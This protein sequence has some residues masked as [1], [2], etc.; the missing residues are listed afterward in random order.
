MPSLAHTTTSVDAVTVMM[1]ETRTWKDV[2]VHA[3]V[4]LAVISVLFVVLHWN[5]IDNMM[6]VA[7]KDPDWSHAFLVPFFSLYF[8]HSKRHAILNTPVRPH[9]LGL[10]VLL[11]A[12]FAHFFAIFPVRSRMLQGYTMI[13]EIVGLSLL[14]LGPQITRLIWF[15]IAYLGFAVQFSN[16]IWNFVAWQLQYFA[17]NSA[18][19]LMN[20][21]GVD[22]DVR[23]STIELWH[24]M[25]YLGALN[26]AEACS[27]LRMLIAFMALG[28]AIVYIVDRPWWSR[29]VLLALTVPI[30]VLVN[31]LRVTITGLLHLVSPD[32]SAGDFHTFVGMLMVIPAVAMFLAVGYLLD[33]LIVHETIDEE[34]ETQDAPTGS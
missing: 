12:L 23:G 31:V 34:Q 3:W 11:L 18:A 30:A 27:G 19:Q 26:V 15:P 7:R 21:L 9:W 6:F 8:I 22:A 1:D 14:L 17:A 28:V 33:H 10:A 24:D 25:D 5:W 2:P 29:V 13:V 20:I 32:L 4:Q 16:K